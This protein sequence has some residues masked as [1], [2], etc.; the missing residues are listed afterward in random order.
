MRT[1]VAL[2]LI[3]FLA[4]NVGITVAHVPEVVGA[5]DARR[6]AVCAALMCG[7]VV[8]LWGSV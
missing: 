1:A 8:Y 3:A 2:V 4:V 7:G 6:V 5:R